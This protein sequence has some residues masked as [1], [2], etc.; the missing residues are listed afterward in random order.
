MGAPLLI[1]IPD[2]ARGQ[3]YLETNWADTPSV[4]FVRILRIRTDTGEATVVRANVSTDSSGTYMELSAGVAI[5]YDAEAPMDVAL[6]YRVDGLG[7]A[8]TYTTADLILPD[9]TFWLKDPRRPAANIAIGLRGAQDPGCVGQLSTFFG[10]MGIEEHPGQGGT[11]SVLNR[12]NPVPVSRL[13]AGIS[14]T[15]TLITRTFTDRDNLIRLAAPGEP[16]LL[17]APAPYGISD[18]YLHV[19]GSLSISRLSPDHRRQ[20]RVATIPH[21]EVD[22]P[23]G[24]SYGAQGSRWRDMCLPYATY[25]AAKTA[26]VRW[27]HAMQGGASQPWLGVQTGWRSYDDLTAEFAT[28]ADIEV[29]LPVRTYD[30]LL[31]GL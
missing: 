2:P 1:A 10:N 6:H 25:N 9:G 19:P 5:L 11:S 7:S 23:A 8:L 18:R 30:Q 3:V 20:W 24:L 28:Y 16:L 13:R 21:Y 15:L 14:S 17:Q 27:E 29:P 22:R 4:T 26:N 31:T 12:K